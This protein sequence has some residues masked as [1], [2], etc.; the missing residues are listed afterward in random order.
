MLF[1]LQRAIKCAKRPHTFS[2]W[3]L[4]ERRWRELE[5]KEE[6]IHLIVS[7]NYR[8]NLIRILLPEISKLI[9]IFN[10]I[11]GLSTS[12]PKIDIWYQQRQL[13]NIP[14]N[15]HNDSAQWFTKNSTA[16]QE[17]ARSLSHKSRVNVVGQR[18][19]TRYMISAVAGAMSLIYCKLIN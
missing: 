17:N 19:V 14:L 7:G 3:A 18:G 11:R 2:W 5:C 4:T 13:H 16:K 6:E 9:N 1:L 8:Y 12:M 10:L 15:E